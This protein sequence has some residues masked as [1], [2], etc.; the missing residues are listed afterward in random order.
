MSLSTYYLEDGRHFRDSTVVAVAV[1]VVRM[2]PRAIPL[3]MITTKKKQLMSFLR[4]ERS[5]LLAQPWDCV[6]DDLSH[7]GVTN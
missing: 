6:A 5:T 7:Y 3:A 1:T 2:R 4:R